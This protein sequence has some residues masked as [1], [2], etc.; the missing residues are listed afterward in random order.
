MKWTLQGGGD[1][2]CNPNPSADVGASLRSLGC[3]FCFRLVGRGAIRVIFWGVTSR[4][5]FWGGHLSCP[6][7]FSCNRFQV[8]PPSSIRGICI[9][10]AC[11]PIRGQCKMPYGRANLGSLRVAWELSDQAFHS[12]WSCGFNNAK[13]GWARPP[14]EFINCVYCTYCLPVSLRRG[15]IKY[16][17]QHLATELLFLLGSGSKEMLFVAQLLGCQLFLTGQPA[18]RKP[19]ECIPPC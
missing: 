13:E 12:D 19:K 3:V 10:C 15:I 17:W 2:A 8:A 4:I 7:T 18:Q 16:E 5:V 1:L 6:W 14:C 9:L 11:R